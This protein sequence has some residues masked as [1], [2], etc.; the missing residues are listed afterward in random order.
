MIRKRSALVV[1][2]LEHED[3]PAALAIQSESY[4][5]F[6]LENEAAFA[7]RLDVAAP[8]CLAAT[9]NGV[10][11]GYLLAHGWPGQSPPA[12]GALLPR[13][14]PSEVLYIHDL[15]IG[16]AGRGLHIGQELVAQA[17]RMAADDGLQTA[18]LIAVQGAASYW[19]TLGFTEAAVSSS[20][21]AKL[22]TYGADARWMRRPT[23]IATTTT[24][25][26]GSTSPT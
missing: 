6:L 24:T 19:R 26:S 25:S 4:P 5:A 21:S 17:C 1:R 10:L 12:V 23:A 2:R 11:V 16:P 7:S 3:L 13:D 20:L 15:A 18:E 9:V 8:Y 14:A 22:A